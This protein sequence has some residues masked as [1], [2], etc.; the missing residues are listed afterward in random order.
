MP[1]GALSRSIS[2]AIPLRARDHVG[3]S[4]DDEGLVLLSSWRDEGSMCA[5]R[6]LKLTAIAICS[7]LGCSGQ[8]PLRGAGNPPAPSVTS[9]MQEVQLPQSRL[10]RGDSVRI[11]SVVRNISD[12]TVNLVIGNCNEVPHIDGVLEQI[13]T[14]QACLGLLRRIALAPGAEHEE[15]GFAVV[16]L[17]VEPGDYVVRVWHA[18]DPTSRYPDELAMVGKDVTITVT[19]PH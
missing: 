19:T 9:V 3:K 2:V 17:V 13:F 10:A 8:E 16:P 11:V 5:W 12:M 15:L 6:L 4:P 1:P 7:S 18:F 14:R